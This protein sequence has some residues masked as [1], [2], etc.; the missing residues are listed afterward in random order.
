[1]IVAVPPRWTL[2]VPTSFPSIMLY[3]V[4]ERMFLTV[5]RRICTS[6]ID[7]GNWAQFMHTSCSPAASI[8]YFFE[9]VCEALRLVA[10]SRPVGEAIHVDT[11]ERQVV[12]VF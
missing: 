12:F 11:D 2:P 9:D 7:E 4:T 8:L 3:D 1:M 6:V 10:F 5:L